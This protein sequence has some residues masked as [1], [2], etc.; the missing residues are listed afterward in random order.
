MSE[1]SEH[2][3]AHPLEQG[4]NAMNAFRCGHKVDWALVVQFVIG[5]IEPL[6]NGRQAVIAWFAKDVSVK[7]N[8]SAVELR[9]NVRPVL[10]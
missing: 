10:L 6:V 1:L 3:G 5:S 8:G 7:L 9:R 4:S 2:P